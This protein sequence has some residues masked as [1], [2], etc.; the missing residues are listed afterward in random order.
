[1]CLNKNRGITK[2]KTIYIELLLRKELLTSEFYLRAAFNGL[3]Y[4]KEDR[5]YALISKILG[6]DTKSAIRMCGIGLQ[7]HR[8]RE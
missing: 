4:H 7:N 3:K 1:M 5:K 6:E 8:T 2:S